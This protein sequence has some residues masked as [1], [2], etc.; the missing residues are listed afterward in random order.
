MLKLAKLFVVLLVLLVLF[1]TSFNMEKI[2][3][4][5]D[6]NAARKKIET[7]V[8]PLGLHAQV[9]EDVVTLWHNVQE[10]DAKF[11][12]EYVRGRVGIHLNDK[13]FTINPPRDL[14]VKPWDP[15]ALKSVPLFHALLRFMWQSGINQQFAKPL[16]VMA[17]QV[18]EETHLST[19][20][21]E[22]QHVQDKKLLRVWEINPHDEKRRNVFD[23][24][25]L[26]L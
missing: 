20:P 26:N 5:T 21:V 2:I 13:V 23:V 25:N 11:R 17:R 19:I 3:V 15:P 18:W 6:L 1:L 12:F 10:I 22:I 8:K 16:C 7:F 14:P 24:V 4:N 9:V